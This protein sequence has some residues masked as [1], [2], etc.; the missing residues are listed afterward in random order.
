MEQEWHPGDGTTEQAHL[1]LEPHPWAATGTRWPPEAAFPAD[2]HSF[3]NPNAVFTDGKLG[4][5]STGLH[6][7]GLLKMQRQEGW[8]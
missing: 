2:A 3:W 1:G 7:T 8:F 5:L 6:A 4:S